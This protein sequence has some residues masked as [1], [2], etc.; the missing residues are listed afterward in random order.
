[1]FFYK[2]HFSYLHHIK[3]YPNYFFAVYFLSVFSFVANLTPI[4]SDESTKEV[5][6][7]SEVAEDGSG[8]SNKKIKTTSQM[9]E[10]L[11]IYQDYS[12][13]RQYSIFAFYLRVK[14][15]F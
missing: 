13:V 15:M 4:M 12:E 14:I 9:S 7:K 5:S 8:E 10:M 1:M 2:C 11:S 3:R 6:S